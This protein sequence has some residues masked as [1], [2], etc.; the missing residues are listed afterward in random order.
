LG[1][2]LLEQKR[3]AGK[4]R[5]EDQRGDRKRSIGRR[6][7]VDKRVAG[8]DQ[9][10]YCTENDNAELP[11]DFTISLQ[12]DKDTGE[13]N[14]D[15]QSELKTSVVPKAKADL[16]SVIVDREI[17]TMNNQIQ[18]PMGKDSKGNDPRCHA[19]N[20]RARRNFVD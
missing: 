16:P 6:W 11:C 2:S 3:N 14:C 10:Q 15:L 13:K 4:K 7:A 5:I 17:R 8:L 18:D 19:W 9:D 20:L 1:A 12:I